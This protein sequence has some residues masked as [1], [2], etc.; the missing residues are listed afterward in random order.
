MFELS[1]FLESLLV[2]DQPLSSF[3]AKDQNLKRE[4]VKTGLWKLLDHVVM[5]PKYEI[6]LF[7]NKKITLEVLLLDLR[8][9]NL[10]KQIGL[11]PK[12]KFQEFKHC[13][14]FWI[15]A[16]SLAHYIFKIYGLW[17]GIFAMIYLLFMQ[18]FWTEK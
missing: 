10:A 11:H 17:L 18:S 8:S 5:F 15:S 3:P 16:S 6:P 13:Q 2:D 7:R 14:L 1:A 12:I 4:P 9:L